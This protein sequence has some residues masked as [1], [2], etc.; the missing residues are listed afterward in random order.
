MLLACAYEY[1]ITSI[2]CSAPVDKRRVKILNVNF[3][4]SLDCCSD[5]SPFIHVDVFEEK[6]PLSLVT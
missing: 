6:N 4:H 2:Y 1:Y 5:I 3:G